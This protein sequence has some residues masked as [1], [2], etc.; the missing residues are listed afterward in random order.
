[1]ANPSCDRDTLIAASGCFSGQ[2]LSIRKQKALKIYF[3]AAQLAAIGGTNYVGALS[4]TLMADSAC[5][6]TLKPDELV[7]ADLVVEMNNAVAAGAVIGDINADMAQTACV[8]TA[9]MN[10]L[11]AALLHLRCELGRAKNYPQ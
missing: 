7:K 5:K 1:M 9:Q 10:Q 6:A 11:D 4:T 8:E 3:M 2:V